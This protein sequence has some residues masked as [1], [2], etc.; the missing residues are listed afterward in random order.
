MSAQ[1]LRTDT[2]Y[3]L[4]GLASEMPPRRPPKRFCA[5]PALLVMFSANV[6]H[7]VAV[8]LWRFL[9]QPFLLL[10]EPSLSFE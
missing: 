7:G 8:G 1:R 10:A 4:N 9:G 5:V 6:H 2:H 3:P